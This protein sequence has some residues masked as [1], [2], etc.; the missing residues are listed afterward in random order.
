MDGPA[1]EP[2]YGKA[3]LTKC[4]KLFDKQW[5]NFW[6][7]GGFGPKLIADFQVV[8]NI[9]FEY[10]LLRFFFPPPFMVEALSHFL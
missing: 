1:R 7:A 9:Y 10:Y 3:S 8:P 5:E 2:T 4:G 6:K